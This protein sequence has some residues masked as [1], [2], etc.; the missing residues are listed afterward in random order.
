MCACV[1][2]C[3]CVRACARVRVSLCVCVCVCVSVCVCVCVFVC[4]CVCT[5]VYALYTFSEYHLNFYVQEEV[6]RCSAYENQELI[7]A[8]KIWVAKWCYRRRCHKTFECFLEFV[9]EV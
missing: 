8:W 2:V 5:C 7:L 6:T 4:V 3:V 9:F 1:C